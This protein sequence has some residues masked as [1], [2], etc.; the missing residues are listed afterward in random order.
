MKRENPRRVQEKAVKTEIPKGTKHQYEFQNDVFTPKVTSNSTNSEQTTSNSSWIHGAEVFLIKSLP[1]DTRMRKAFTAV[2][3][4]VT[5]VAA[6]GRN[7]VKT[8]KEPHPMAA[9]S[10]GPEEGGS[11]PKTGRDHAKHSYRRR[12]KNLLRG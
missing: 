2:K 10:L 1:D 8:F 6:E 3:L 4:V 7:Q 9:Y 11:D 12:T 5:G